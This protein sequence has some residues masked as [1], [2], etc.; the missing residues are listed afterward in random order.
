MKLQL[1][2]LWLEEKGR[3]ALLAEIKL[4]TQAAG[5]TI[6]IAGHKANGTTEMFGFGL[7]GIYVNR[8]LLSIALSV[9]LDSSYPKQREHE[10]ILQK[11]ELAE[12]LGKQSSDLS[13]WK[14]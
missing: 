11:A 9:R 1:F 14:Q 12:W 4:E 5:A 6:I 3:E 13:T 10:K 2:M 8:G 7:S